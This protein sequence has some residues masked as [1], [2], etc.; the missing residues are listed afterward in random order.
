MIKKFF[1][2]F[3]IFFG[4]L[5][6]GNRCFAVGDYGPNW[7]KDTISVYIPADD[8]YSLMMLHAFQAWQNK[9]YGQLKFEFSDKKPADIEVSFKD[10]T[11][12]TDG[13]LGSYTLIIQGGAITKAEIIIAPQKKPDNL[14]YTVMLHEIGHALGL[15]D[16]SRR[17]GIMHSPVNAEQNLINNDIIKLFRLNGWSYMNKG[18]YASF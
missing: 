9:S 18:T 4:I 8:N 10:K 12:G 14:V 5:V 2:F 13:D 11:D 3:I 1:L 15:R 6:F 17:L 16:S 7:V